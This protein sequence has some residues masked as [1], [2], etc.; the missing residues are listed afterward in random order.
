MTADDTSEA[1]LRVIA[2]S[3]RY[4]GRRE[5][6]LDDVSVEVG[7]RRRVGAGRTGRQIHAGP[8]CCR[9]HPARGPPKLEGRVVIEG[10]DAAT[11]APGACPV[12]WGSCSRPQRPAV[13]SK[14]T[15][16]EELAFGLENLGGR[17]D[18]GRPDR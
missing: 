3:A 16:R 1:P 6:S 10:L 18:D 13:C 4:P 12:R 5:L 7:R 14:L 2:L 8:G 15:V 17:G 9:V 11:A